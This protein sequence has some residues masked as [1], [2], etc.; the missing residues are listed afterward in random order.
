MEQGHTVYSVHAP[1]M[2]LVVRTYLIN[3]AGTAA[4]CG[5]VDH[6][7]WSWVL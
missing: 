1:D 2:I 3:L 4:A 5:G 7:G 6:A